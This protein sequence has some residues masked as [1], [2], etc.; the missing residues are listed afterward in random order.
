MP[1]Q[2]RP[3]MEKKRPQ[4]TLPFQNL[5]FTYDVILINYC[6]HGNISHNATGSE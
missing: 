2:N 3:A 4:F 1:F 5:C 6:H